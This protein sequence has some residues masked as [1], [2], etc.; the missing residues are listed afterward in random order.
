MDY[1]L[2]YI[3]YGKHTDLRPNSNP[4]SLFDKWIISP[5]YVMYVYIKN[6]TA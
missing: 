6:F 5:T 3:K 1:A 2:H 4:N